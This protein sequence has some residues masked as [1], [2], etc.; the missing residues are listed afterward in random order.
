MKLWAR[1]LLVVYDFLS[2]FYNNASFACP[3]GT[4]ILQP[5]WQRTLASSWPSDHKNNVLYYREKAICLWIC[6]QMRTWEVCK[7]EMDGNIMPTQYITSPLLYTDLFSIFLQSLLSWGHD[8][9][10][11]IWKGKIW[12]VVKKRDGL[13]SV[14]MHDMFHTLLSNIMPAEESF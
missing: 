14:S 1:I 13:L 12:P 3:F 4:I 2:M 9:L 11:W 10:K 6:L 7:A 5:I 8:G